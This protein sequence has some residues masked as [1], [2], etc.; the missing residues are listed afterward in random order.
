MYFFKDTGFWKDLYKNKT[1]NP[2]FGDFT[3]EEKLRFILI[4]F[5]KNFN[6]AVEDLKAK[7][8]GITSFIS[9]PIKIQYLNYLNVFSTIDIQ[10]SR[11]EVLYTMD[12]LCKDSLLKT[13]KWRMTWTLLLETMTLA[14]ISGWRLL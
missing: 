4:H 13:H 7:A 9:R 11:A 2:L 1:V 8:E 14:I 12:L 3:I 6:I 5:H 10:S